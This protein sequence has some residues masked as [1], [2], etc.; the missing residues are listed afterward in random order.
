MQLS[1][2]KKQ[3]LS[4]YVVLFVAFLVGNATVSAQVTRPCG[5]DNGLGGSV[6]RS[7]SDEGDYTGEFAGS[8]VF[9]PDP[10]GDG[11]TNLIFVADVFTGFTSRYHADD[12]RTEGVMISPRGSA[13][14][15]GL[16][17]HSVED[18]LYWAI[19]GD[20]ISTDVQRGARAIASSFDGAVEVGPI[21]IDGLVE[22]LF[23][24][25]GRAGVVGD[26]TYHAGRD[27]FWAVDV[28]NDLYFEINLDGTLS[29]D[30]KGAPIFFANPRSDASGAGAYGNTITYVN[31]GDGEFFDIP[32]GT[33]TDG[34][35]VEVVRVHAPTDPAAAGVAIGADTGAGYDIINEL[36]ASDRSETA[37]PTGVAF[38]SNTCGEDQNSEILVIHDAAGGP[39]TIHD[40]S[41]DPPAVLNVANLEGSSDGSAAA[42]LSWDKTSYETLQ[43]VRRNLSDRD[44]ADEF[45]FTSTF[46][47]DTGSFTDVDFGVPPRGVFLYTVRT[48]SGDG[49]ES[50]PKST[51]VTV[52]PGRLVETFATQANDSNG[53]LRP[54]TSTGITSTDEHLIVA[55]R[56]TGIATRY[57]LGTLEADGTITGPVGIFGET[58]GIEYHPES[59]L[60]FWLGREGNENFLQATQ[61]DGTQ[62]GA[63]RPIQKPI[64]R[65]RQGAYGDLSLDP[66]DGN[67][68]LADKAN[69]NVHACTIEGLFVA[70]SL[71]EGPVADSVLGGGIEVITDGID[72]DFIMFDLTAGP[73]ETGVADSLVRVIYSRDQLGQAGDVRSTVH[74]GRTINVRE[75]VANLTMTENPGSLEQDVNTFVVAADTNR[76]YQ[77]SMNESTLDGLPFIR[78][79]ANNDGDINISDPSFILAFL[80]LGAES[81][82][83]PCANAGDTD[84]SGTVDMTD[85]ISLFSYLFRGGAAP[86]APG[87]SCGFDATPSD[88]E[89]DESACVGG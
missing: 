18:K 88:L 14:T 6:H 47:D 66:R 53:G 43:I 12:F 81:R 41:A 33:I 74:I 42:M 76:I 11:S 9:V 85:A 83:L 29:T 7:L 67:F 63:R 70:G 27:K 86:A 50:Q 73:A 21:D 60:L 25:A 57:K 28:A 19:D 78:G 34:R 75:P 49:S 35:P 30:A 52:G 79:D 38:R 87:V 68:W 23:G 82:P 61:L 37:F 62:P 22:A 15:T 84:D 13:S 20:L 89:C 77:L 51:V 39:A 45:V 69:G 32:V 3:P 48:Q 16:T 54:Q 1:R 40:V 36:V 4:G 71:V 64:G 24:D 31:S 5:L 8:V 55:D 65:R 80:F 17:Y 72:S 2:K 26:I 56:F 46:D 59:G 10:D 44:S 58:T